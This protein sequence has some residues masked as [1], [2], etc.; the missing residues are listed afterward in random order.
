MQLGR[1]LFGDERFQDAEVLLRSCRRSPASAYESLG[2]CSW[3]GRRR[4]R[5]ELSCWSSSRPRQVPDAIGII[6]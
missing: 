6:L 3:Q 4:A 5:Q 1:V 2:H